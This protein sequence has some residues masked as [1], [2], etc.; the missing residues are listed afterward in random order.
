M[1]LRDVFL[2]FFELEISSWMKLTA[3]LSKLFWLIVLCIQLFNPFVPAYGNFR[4]M[5][6]ARIA[7]MRIFLYFLVA[8]V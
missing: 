4:I 6:M 3:V 1:D 8:L 2:F 5:L 7:H